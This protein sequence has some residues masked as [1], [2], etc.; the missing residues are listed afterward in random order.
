[1]PYLDPLVLRETIVRLYGPAG[2]GQITSWRV[3]S[4]T[5][6]ELEAYLDA[7]GLSAE[8]S[9]AEGEE[10]TATSLPSESVEAALPSGDWIIFATL[11][12]ESGSSQPG[13]LRRF[14]AEHAD[15]LRDSS[16]IVLAFDAP[17]YLD[18][19]EISKLSAYYVAYS[20]TAS[21]VEQTIR[22]LFGEFAPGGTPPVSVAGV[23]YDIV[24]QTSPDPD[25]TIALHYRVNDLDSEGPTPGP[26]MDGQSTSTEEERA[27][28]EPRLQ[29]GDELVLRTGVIVDHNGHPVPDG[30]LVQFFFTYP[31]EGLE[32]SET[33]VTA[34]GV[35]ETAITLDQDRTGQLDVSIQAE[36]VPR[37]L[38]LRVTLQE[39]EASS[40][41]TLE[42][43]PTVAA[44]LPVTSAVEVPLSKT[45]VPTPGPGQG[46]A[47]RESADVGSLDLV[48]ALAGVMLVGG[49]GYTAVRS[50]GASAI[51]ALRVSL[52]CVVG[53]LA[54]YLAYALRLPGAN[55]LRR[56][57][58]AWAAA[59][60][61]LAGGLIP[62]LSSRAMGRWGLQ[63]E[64]WPGL[65][66]LKAG[67][68]H[69]EDE[70]GTGQS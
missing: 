57:V 46:F 41:A 66:G 58:G 27:T 56:Q 22:A 63:T 60:V 43:S 31:Q 11:K 59:W 69:G 36:P 29:A 42:P 6:D 67:G 26:T 34:G 54:L 61:A 10:P 28:Q 44:T 38:V 2:T 1:V 55:W 49:L 3:S 16:L 68:Y 48:L 7:Q 53:G 45:P 47:G 19:T 50:G 17:Y 39:G 15:A 52:W 30:T 8:P 13:I 65:G 12:P 64:R 37:T 14:L 62:L 20:W 18:A 33:A 35:A 21:F 24:V 70:H 23:N 40:V 9:P 32:R 51:H 4:F 5:F 25:Q